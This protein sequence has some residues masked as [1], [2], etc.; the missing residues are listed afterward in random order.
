[1]R[2]GNGHPY[3]RRAAHHCAPLHVVL[4]TKVGLGV[5]HREQA[6]VGDRDAVRA[7]PD[8]NREPGPARRTA[9]LHSHANSDLRAFDRPLE[10]P[11]GTPV[12]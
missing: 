7:S 12:V 10:E 9:A 8:I 1:M 3:A 6:I 11:I 5:V 2:A 4:P